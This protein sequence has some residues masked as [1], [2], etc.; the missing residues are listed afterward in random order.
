MPSLMDI[1]TTGIKKSSRRS[2]VE[3]KKRY[4]ITYSLLDSWLWYVDNEWSDPESAKKDFETTLNRERIPDN[5]YMQSG[6]DFESCVRQA[7]KGNIFLEFFQPPYGHCVWKVAEKIKKG[8]WQATGYQE[9]DVNGITYILYGKA[10]VLR[11]PD[12]F[13]IK[14]TRKYQTGKYYNKLQHPMYF[15]CFPGVQSFTYLISNG[16][17]VFEETYRRDSTGKVEDT[18]YDFQQWLINHANYQYDYFQK[19]LAL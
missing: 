18:I 14:F 6:R 17:E 8:V 19:W 7:D 4:L 12:V 3:N 15:A 13:D 1:L 9:V 16:M 11:G 10:D 2:P 5:V